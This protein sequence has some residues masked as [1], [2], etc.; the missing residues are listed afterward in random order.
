MLI[1]DNL[2]NIHALNIANLDI[3]WKKNFGVPFKSNLKVHNNNLYLI[4]SNSKIYSINTDNGKLNWSFET[5][6]RDL[7]D[8]KSYQIAIINDDLVFTNDNAEIY[9]L[10]LKKIISNG[11]LFFRLLILKTSHYFLNLVQFQ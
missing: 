8:N 6:S 5:A 10:D 11:L 1:A 7:K 4:N 9:C 2:G 3:I